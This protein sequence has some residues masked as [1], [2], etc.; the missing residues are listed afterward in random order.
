M[1]ETLP[2]RAAVC[3]LTA[4]ALAAPVAAAEPRDELLR[5]V[6]DD[7]G[8]C[9]VVQDLRGR[10]ADV[11]DSPFAQA[12]AKSPL[13]A[14]FAGAGE[15]KQLSDVEKYLKQHLGVGWKELRDDL[16][17]D[18]FVF[19]YR[20]GPIDKP[21]QEQG[22]FLVRAREAKPLAEFV[23]KLNKLQKE[24]GELKELSEREHK[25][26]KY[27]RRTE[28]KQTSYYLLRDSVLVYSGQEAF[29]RQLIE[30][31]L[32]AQK[33][34]GEPPLTKRLRELGLEKA[35]AA[36]LVRP[37]TFD[38]AV[39]AKDDPGSKTV[40]KVWKSVDNL[41]L[42]L[43]IGREVEISLA[44]KGK[45]DQLPPPIRRLL[46]GTTKASD[47]WSAFPQDALFAAAARIDAAALYETL[48]EL[49]PKSSKDAADAEL[50]RTLGAM[51]GKS[52][53]KEVL[54]AL[55]PDVGLCV[56][57]PSDK[58]AWAPRVLAAIRVARGSDDDPTDEAVFSGLESWAQLLVVSHNKKNPNQTLTLKSTYVDR[59]KVRY[60]QGEGV[61]PVGV[62]PAFGLR[63]GFLVVCTSL[64]D[65][66][67]F[68]VTSTQTS[69]PVPLA[70]A[71]VKAIRAYLK[72]H[73][74]PLA[75]M[76]SAREKTTKDKALERIDDLRANLELIDRVEL[77][78]QTTAGRVTLT[79]AVQPAKALKK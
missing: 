55:G 68:K 20:P 11:L 35:F 18:C 75:A 56:T 62:Q 1:S 25:G 32:I 13:A 30:R 63:G 39:A 8:F 52:I 74:D 66:R 23:R 44:L 43:T 36:L 22:A 72:D 2:S 14:R 65:L 24:S 59:A 58:Q 31:D 6:P 40:A 73:R 9:L 77:R 61:L 49:M 38:A 69:G 17:G 78:Q 10:S 70:R 3:L 64:A 21:D 79:L 51:L 47:L 50:E 71:S 15:W 5:F 76:L 42:G 7:V 33:D 12:F 57:A 41:G 29:L 28:K 34:K 46:V 48:G 16:L 67:K 54:P 60:L 37:R 19:T 53:L 27:V 26:V 4:L 45:A